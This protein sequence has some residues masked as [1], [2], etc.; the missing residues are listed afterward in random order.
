M[1]LTVDTYAHY[2]G[3]DADIAAIAR[4]NRALGANRGQL[5]ARCKQEL[6]SPVSKSGL[7]SANQTA[8]QP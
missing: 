3:T 5:F 1:T 8:K 2:M 4:M 6:A 7:A